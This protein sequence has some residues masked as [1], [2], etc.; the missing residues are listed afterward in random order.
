[1]YNNVAVRSHPLEEF[2]SITKEE[3]NAAGKLIRPNPCDPIIRKD[4]KRKPVLDAF[5]KILESHDDLPAKELKAW[6]KTIKL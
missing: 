2:R 6:I 4:R 5:V 3:L 1:M